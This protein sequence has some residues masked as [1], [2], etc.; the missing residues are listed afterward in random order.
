MNNKTQTVIGVD[1]SSRKLDLHDNASGSHSIIANEPKEIRAWVKRLAARK[2]PQIVVMEATG[3]YE[4]TLVEILHDHDIACAVSNPLQVRNFARGLGLLEKNDKIDAKMIARFGEVVDPRRQEKPTPDE[5]KLKAL[6]HRRNQI[7]SQISAE[8]NRIEQTADGE[9][10]AMVKLAVEFYKQQIKEVDR[11]IER[12]VEQCENLKAKAEILNS[13]PG[14]GKATV[15]TLLAELPELGALNRGQV[16]KLVGVAPIT[17]DSGKSSRKRSVFAG[18]STVRKVLYMAALVATRYN[19]PLQ[20]FYQRL[21]ANG[22]PKKLALVAVMR[23]LLV[24]LNTMIKNQEPWRETKLA[25]D[26]T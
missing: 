19:E 5:R 22:K 14:V 25:I 24:T 20:R 23:K 9:T 18:R 10:K 3:G 13:V 6:V 4:N 8:K 21:L 1:V 16:A 7:L 15:G 26:K 17:R 2:T 12:T 11:S